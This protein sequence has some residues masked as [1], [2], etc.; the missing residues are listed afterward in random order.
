MEK[1]YLTTYQKSFFT[2]C[3]A[4]RTLIL[5]LKV[6]TLSKSFGHEFAPFSRH[7]FSLSIILILLF[8]L[9]LPD[10]RVIKVGGERFKA[11]EALFQ[12]HLVNVEGQ[13]KS[14]SLDFFFL[15]FFLFFGEV[16]SQ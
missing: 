8:I 14:I 16:L 12:P 4:N 15:F 3:S 1:L 5:L 7:I 6:G 2:A 9:Q 11:P 13:G 10:G